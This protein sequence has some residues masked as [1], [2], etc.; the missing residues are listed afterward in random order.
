VAVGLM[1]LWAASMA[2]A[3]APGSAAIY[4]ALALG[5][6]WSIWRGSRTTI[7]VEEGSR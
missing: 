3:G 1:V 5:T 4:S 6:V 2:V 7:R